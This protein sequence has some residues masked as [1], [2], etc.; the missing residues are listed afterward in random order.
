MQNKKAQTGD[1]LTLAWMFFLFVIIFAVASAGLLLLFGSPPDLK[2]AD[3]DSLN[4]KLKNCLIKNEISN[5][6]EL[7][8]KCA[9]N[10]EV[11]EKNNM[12]I[13]QEN[14]LI[15]IQEGRGEEALCELSEKNENYPKCAVSEITKN[16]KQIK[17]TTGSWQFIS[18]T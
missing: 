8:E 17:I 9:L 10:K 15:F 1:F 5:A 16:E 13:I 6:E 2:Q 4:I 12:I 14:N 3:A 7:Y 18:K 11:I